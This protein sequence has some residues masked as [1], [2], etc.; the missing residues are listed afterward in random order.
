MKFPFPLFLHLSLLLY[1]GIKSYAGSFKHNTNRTYSWFRVLLITLDCVIFCIKLFIID[2]YFC[3]C[4]YACACAN[5]RLRLG[6]FFTCFPT[7]IFLRQ[8]LLSH[9]ELISQLAYLATKSRASSCLH[10]C[11]SRCWGSQLRSSFF[12]G[13][14][15][16]YCAISPVHGHALFYT[17]GD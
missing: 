11:R 17:A 9:A 1:L 16:N 2:T 7:W 3:V 4:V 15:F 6:V 14:C 5:S 13:T 10:L 8:G 12:G